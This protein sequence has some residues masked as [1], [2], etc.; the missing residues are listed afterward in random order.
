MLQQLQDGPKTAD[1]LKIKWKE[2]FQ[3]NDITKHDINV[4]CYQNLKGKV[5]PTAD[6]P[7]KFKLM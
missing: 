2:E 1:E 3:D 5:A 6:K 7:P 4:F